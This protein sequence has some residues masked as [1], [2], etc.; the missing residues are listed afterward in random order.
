MKRLVPALSLLVVALLAGACAPE[1]D[2][3]EPTASETESEA[4]DDGEV[5]AAGA[6]APADLPTLTDGVLTIATDEPAFEPWFSEDDPSNG[7]G[8]EAAVAYAVAE[9]LGYDEETVEWVRVPFN[10]AIA[11]GPKSFDFDINQFTITEER[12]A[13]VDF[14]TP[15]YDVAQAV[16]ATGD[17]PAAGVT[18]IAGQAELQ[19]GAQV[20]TTS[21]DAAAEVLGDDPQTF[22]T[23]DD[24][25]VALE[26]GQIDALVVDLPTAFFITA[27]ELEDGVV[28]GQLPSAGGQAEQ[29]GIV[30]DLGS[31]LTDCLSEVVDTLRDDGTLAEL[32]A[33]W[34]ADVAGA[35]ELQ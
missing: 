7:E 29:F 20:G 19:I 5:D 17:S 1:E 8:F 25:K 33:Q 26:N 24:A 35:P 4:G 2:T 18:E 27:A 14:S 34:L 23:N 21:F 10:A 13:A 12:R 16:I 31:P 11:P 9:H 30:L 6:C 32:E 28:V 15:Y 22:N 3:P